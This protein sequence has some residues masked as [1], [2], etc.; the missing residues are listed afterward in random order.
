MCTYT[1]RGHQLATVSTTNFMSLKTCAKRRH[2]SVKNKRSMRRIVGIRSDQGRHW[3]W[4]WNDGLLYSSLVKSA[5]T[6]E[7]ASKRDMSNRSRSAFDPYS[8]AIA[9]VRMAQSPQMWKPLVQAAR[10]SGNSTMMLNDTKNNSNPAVFISIFS[11]FGRIKNHYF[12]AVVAFAGIIFRS[13]LH[14]WT[15]APYSN[16]PWT[17][18]TVAIII[19]IILAATSPIVNTANRIW[20]KLQQKKSEKR[21][22]RSKYAH[23]AVYETRVHQQQFRWNS[24]H[25]TSIPSR[26]NPW[27]KP[28]AAPSIVC[29]NLG[30]RGQLFLFPVSTTSML[31]SKRGSMIAGEIRFGNGNN[32]VAA[33]HRRM[34]KLPRLEDEEEEKEWCRHL[35]S[36]RSAFD[37]WR[38]K[39]RRRS[40]VGTYS[41]AITKERMAQST[42]EAVVAEATRSIN[43]PQF[44]H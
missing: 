42:E 16:H 12:R 39:R 23:N 8:G 43:D 24:R 9:I 14:F 6:S 11:L 38:I 40:A 15:T 37:P 13:R 20:N 29:M 33:A 27:D 5:T 25:N 10:T 26:K 19:F 1:L 18:A 17:L 7:E 31:L 3:W 44:F 36:S 28:A 2:G 21:T 34:M 22:G 4:R 32:A 30:M 35:L 41:R